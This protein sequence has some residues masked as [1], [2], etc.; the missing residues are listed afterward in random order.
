MPRRVQAVIERS[1]VML[2]GVGVRKERS[3][4]DQGI[5]S[6]QKLLGAERIAGISARRLDELKEASRGI[7]EMRSAERAKDVGALLPPRE[8]WRLL[9]AWDD[10]FA[11]LDVEAVRS[12]AS[13]VPVIVSLKR[14]RQNP[15][16]LV[17]GDDLSWRTL[18]EHLS[19]IDFLV[20]FNG[21]SFD[22]P[23][24]KGNGY[25]I[26]APLHLDL[27]GYCRR[28]R[29]PGG[30]KEIERRIGIG[31]SRELE[32]STSEQVSYLWRA[33]EN[34]GNKNALDLLI[35]YNQQDVDSLPHL[36][37]CIYRRLTEATVRHNSG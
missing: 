32:F 23:L 15:R 21:S 5:S 37:G 10:S 22:L 13:F 28:A 30:L 14:G 31:R 11:A 9:G 24:L 2:P 16:T 8:R 33:W 12:G 1:F 7:M 20:T 25:D 29:L 19:D 26:D 34:S 36:A 18:K 27:R 17:R 6:W 4:W 35:R 3:M